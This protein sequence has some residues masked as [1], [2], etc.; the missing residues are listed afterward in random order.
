M[1][2]IKFYERG[3]LTNDTHTFINRHRCGST[4]TLLL[5]SNN[6]QKKVVGELKKYMEY[7]KWRTQTQGKSNKNVNNKSELHY[8]MMN[9]NQKYGLKIEFSVY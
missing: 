1:K 4:H 8:L 5:N 6:A 7:R 3:T 2:E 9:C